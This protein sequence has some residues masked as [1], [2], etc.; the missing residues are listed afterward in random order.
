M[1]TTPISKKIGQ[2]DAPTSQSQGDLLVSVLEFKRTCIENGAAP[3]FGGKR[4]EEKISS[5]LDEIKA[6][7]RGESITPK[8]KIM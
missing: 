7:L 2:K 1:A 8:Q 3:S 5:D 6:M 4:G